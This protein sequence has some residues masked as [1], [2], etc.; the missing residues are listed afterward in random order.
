M[1]ASATTSAKPM[2]L[3][4]RAKEV[5]D[6]VQSILQLSDWLDG[7]RTVP[8]ELTS[9]HSRLTID[10]LEARRADLT[11]WQHMFHESLRRYRELV[12]MTP[13]EWASLEAV[14]IVGLEGMLGQATLGILAFV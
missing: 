2:T 12:D 7:E 5:R 11:E 13:A 6:K 9:L 14:D 3:D 8:P 1:T 4:I 10:R